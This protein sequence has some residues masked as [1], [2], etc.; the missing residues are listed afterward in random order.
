M[1]STLIALSVAALVAPAV[2]WWLG[3]RGFY[4]IALA[5]VAAL[6]WVLTHWPTNGPRVE[7]VQW[8]PRLQMTFDM[9]MDTLSAVMAVL[10]L[11]IGA[12]VLCYCANYFD[13]MRPRVAMFGGE[14]LAFATA[15]FGLVVSDNTLILYVFWEI[16]TVLSF[17]LVGFYGIRASSR[18]AA[19]QALLVTTLGGLAMLG[20]IIAL[21]T[22][23]GSYLLSDLIAH[24]PASSVYVDIAVA[25]GL[26]SDAVVVFPGDGTGALG[27]AQ[28][29][30]G[31]PN[32]GFDCAVGDVDADGVDDLVVGRFVVGTN[33]ALI[34]VHF[35]GA[36][37]PGDMVEIAGAPGLVQA[38]E[39][40][41]GD[42]DGDGK[43]EWIHAY[44]DENLPGVKNHRMPL[45]CTDRR[46]SGIWF[47]GGTYSVIDGWLGG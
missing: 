1:L 27:A 35:G 16:T 6:V 46:G 43:S 26:K 15:M 44:E 17:L 12:L 36:A 42:F 34:T 32:G 7:S 41:V 19:T 10:I 3:P 11:G 47:C 4:V 5:P 13:A 33:T 25:E 22:R 21:G 40:A 24:P 31:S 28:A 30:A 2:M 20:G 9:R 8:I 39:V 37:F 18:R 14:M 38:R 23:T 29:V 45:V